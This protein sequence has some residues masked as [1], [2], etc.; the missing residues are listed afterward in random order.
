LIGF[1]HKKTGIEY[2]VFLCNGVGTQ[3]SLNARPKL[4]WLASVLKGPF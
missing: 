1:G 2:P 4:I 3:N